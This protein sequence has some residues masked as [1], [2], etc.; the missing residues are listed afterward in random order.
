MPKTKKLKHTP[1]IQT[2]NKH[3]ATIQVKKM[4]VDSLSSIGISKCELPISSDGFPVRLVTSYDLE[5]VK[6]MVARLRREIQK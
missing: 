1:V 5:A 2:K 3:T 4:S 6:E